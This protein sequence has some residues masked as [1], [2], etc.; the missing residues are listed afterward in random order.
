[1]SNSIVRLALVASVVKTSP[2]VRFQ[3]SQAS[4]VPSARSAD[5]GTSPSPQQPLELG[6]AE[7]RVEHEAGA[8]RARG[9]ARPAA[10]SS[11][12]RAA[13]RRSCHTMARPYGRPVARSQATTVSRWLVI[14]MAATE[15]APTWSTTSCSVARAASQISSASCSTQPGRG[16]CWVNSRYDATLGR[17]VDEHGAAA[18]AGRAGIDGH[19]AGGHRR[20]PFVGRFLPADV[21]RV[22]AGRGRPASAATSADAAR[23]AR[24]RTGPRRVEV[25]E[26]LAGV[27]ELGQ[28]VAQP[29][30]QRAADEQTAEDG[31]DV[32]VA[33]EEDGE[34]DGHDRG[35]DQP[36]L[37]EP[38]PRHR[39]AGVPSHG[40]IDST[41]RRR[42][43]AAVAPS[44]APPVHRPTL[45]A[46]S[47]ASRHPDRWWRLPRSERR[48][49][50]HR[51]QGRAGA[52]RRA[53]RVPRRVGRCPRAAHG[54]AEHRVDAG[55]AAPRRH[56][57]GH[58]AGEP[59]RLADRRPGGRAPRCR[60]SGSTA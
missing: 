46:R 38:T 33:A 28:D 49:P 40:A 30:V 1:M 22:G 18:D 31:E 24:R 15:P 35:V 37:G 57:A 5:T 13:V 55:H 6:A 39:S 54:P 12:Q 19:H 16:K 50:G 21:R 7:V 3:I 14:P 34:D 56:G 44:T 4:I 60:T 20:L 47:G 51:A 52:R 8:L 2:P 9:R 41:P 17:A 11:S 58:P 10:A 23:G 26:R 45:Y 42:D 59:V 48:D 53:R 36:L 43:R 32:A 27:A 25:A 29:Q